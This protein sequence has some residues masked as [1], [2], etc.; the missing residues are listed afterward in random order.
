M[1]AGH[2]E[3]TQTKQDG[4]RHVAGTL[5][6]ITGYIRKK[7]QWISKIL[8]YIDMYAG[9]GANP[10]TGDGSAVIALKLLQEHNPYHAHLIECTGTTFKKLQAK[11]QGFADVSLH[12]GKN[13]D[14]MR[15]QQLLPADGTAYGLCYADPNGLHDW[16]LLQEVFA[17]KRYK[18]IDL[19]LYVN[20]TAIKR[21]LG[22]KLITER[23]SEDLA[24]IKKEKWFIGPPHGASQWTFFLGMN[25]P[26][27]KA[28]NKVKFVGLESDEGQGRL[29]RLDYTENEREG[30]RNGD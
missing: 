15:A 12:H 4:F 27:M 2:G 3:F 11:C 29:L 10:G 6:K 21:C 25:W 28:L 14:I 24:K 19:L 26:A 18:H 30:M 5:M 7:H 1:V 23:L 8:T 17:S 16:G 9:A 20:A 22:V 13:G